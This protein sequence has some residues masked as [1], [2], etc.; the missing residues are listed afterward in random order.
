MISLNAT[1]V[2]CA[3]G[4]FDCGRGS[5]HGSG[6]PNSIANSRKRLRNLAHT[7]CEF[8]RCALRLLVSFVLHDIIFEAVRDAELFAQP[9][10][11]LGLRVL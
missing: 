7:L 8:R 4:S 6:L 9:E 2:T 1:P 11:S 3:S 10:D 5:D